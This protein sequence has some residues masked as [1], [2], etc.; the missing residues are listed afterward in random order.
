M[1][2]ILM[3]NTALGRAC[4]VVS[5]DTGCFARHAPEA[6]QSAQTILGL[7]R[8][9]LDEAG[10]KK[11]DAVAVVAGPGSFTGTR[12]GV[13][14]A[15]GLCAAWDV[16]GLPVS[17]L[18]L[19]AAA[20]LRQHSADTCL[21]AIRSRGDEMYFGCYRR[22]RGGPVRHGSEQAG[23]LA[24]LSIEPLAWL[25]PPPPQTGFQPFRALETVR[26]A[27]A[28]WG[29]VIAAGEGWPEAAAIKQQFEQFGL[30]LQ[31]AAEAVAHVAAADEDLVQVARAALDRGECVAA[32]LLRPNYVAANPQYREHSSSG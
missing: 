4:A 13:A 6:R 2:S 29:R 8:E 28:G 25:A 16:P 10:L 26:P 7:A 3:L 20:A 19:T 22:A 5:H 30:G 24:R 27:V 9:A 15:Q 31:G 1:P 32:D 11:P 21:A 18:A 23:S 14:A 17:S 12:I